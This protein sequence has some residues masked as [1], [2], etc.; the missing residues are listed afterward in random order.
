MPYLI[1]H[2]LAKFERFDAFLILCGDNRLRLLSDP[3]DFSTI[4]VL[5]VA[6]AMC[7]RLSI[8]HD[9]HIRVRVFMSA[10]FDSGTQYSG[11]HSEPQ[12][13]SHWLPIWHG[14]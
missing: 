7:G 1:E 5:V 4:E 8:N 9:V 10:G 14:G 6:E 3:A 13:S 2:N 11:I 12:G